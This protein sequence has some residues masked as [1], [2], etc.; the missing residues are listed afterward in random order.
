S[1]T[2]NLDAWAGQTIRLLVEAADNGP[3]NLL[4]AG[5]DDVRVYPVGGTAGGAHDGALSRLS[6]L[7]GV[8]NVGR[9]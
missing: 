7:R 4:E 3:D 9:Q 8:A 5:L 2:V 1:R 6:G